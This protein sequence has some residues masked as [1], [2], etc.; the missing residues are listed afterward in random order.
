MQ[1]KRKLSPLDWTHKII[2][3]NQMI[4]SKK[5]WNTTI[6]I[7][8]LG[9]LC[10][11]IFF[12]IVQAHSV[13]N[14]AD[15][16]ANDYSVL[17][18][19]SAT[20]DSSQVS[21]VNSSSS[22]KSSTAKVQM[23]EI[24]AFKNTT[25]L[26]LPIIMYHHI[27]GWQG[28]EG[29]AIE[30]GLRVA[31]SVFEQH[32]LYIKQNKY[33]TITT[34]DLYK[35][36]TGQGTLP[37]NPI[38]LTFDDGYTD[39]NTLA[40]PLMKQYGMIGDFAII[41]GRVGDTGYM[42]WDQIKELQAAGNYFSSHTINH[43]QLASKNYDAATRGTTP[44]L[45]TPGNDDDRPCSYKNSPEQLDAG[46]VRYELRESKKTL[47]EKL[48]IPI[49]SIVYPFGGHNKTVVKIA[50]EENYQLGFTVVGQGD[51]Q[52]DLTDPLQI[53]RYRGFGQNVTGS[54]QG[55]FAGGR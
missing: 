20:S 6:S 55:F 11:L 52:V 8:V 9:A 3:K 39:N 26:T 51:E 19:S 23:M 49:V 12:Y 40:L 10:T 25:S 30:Q 28:A 35:Y 18:L 42:T 17:S 7:G 46:Q 45:A 24:K 15:K 21:L 22:V 36:A 34:K 1:Y 29:D 53:P 13:K 44:W 27:L 2:Y 33:E 43:C 47:E 38:L 16:T 37:A 31:P 5:V 4:M 50:A 32:L 48:G 14:M 41:T 54:L